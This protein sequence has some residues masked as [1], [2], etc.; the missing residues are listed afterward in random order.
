LTAR[1]PRSVGLANETVFEPVGYAADIVS[2]T[3]TMALSGSRLSPAPA[4]VPS[5]STA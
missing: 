3:S 4:T 1:T 5:G 2:S